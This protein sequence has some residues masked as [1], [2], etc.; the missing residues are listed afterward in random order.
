M[1]SPAYAAETVPL[2]VST[3]SSGNGCRRWGTRAALEDLALKNLYIAGSSSLKDTGE[4]DA[5]H[6]PGG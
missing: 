6:L 1:N 3:E 4:E 2:P 5:A